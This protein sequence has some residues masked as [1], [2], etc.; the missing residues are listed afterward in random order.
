MTDY[1]ID[2]ANCGKVRMSE[3][4]SD[5]VTPFKSECPECGST[6]YHVPAFQ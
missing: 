6:E 5:G 4:D 3:G 1:R 2:C